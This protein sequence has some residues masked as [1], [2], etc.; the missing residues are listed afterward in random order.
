[1]REPTNPG[2]AEETDTYAFF[3]IKN[4]KNAEGKYDVAD[5]TATYLP[6]LETGIEDVVSTA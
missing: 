6:Y 1:M 4:T 5:V 2:W 3:V